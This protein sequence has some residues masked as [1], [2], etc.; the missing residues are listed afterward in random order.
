MQ[1]DEPQDGVSVHAGFPNPAADK[2]LQTLDFNQLLIQHGAST[3]MFR[4]EGNQWESIG[5]FDNDIAVVDRALDPRK[6][7][8]TV[9]WNEQR[10]EFS[11]SHHASMPR[12][13]SCWGVVTNTIHQFRP[14]VAA[15]EG[16]R[17]GK[18]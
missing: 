18:L 10:G 6:N 15:A 13:A 2:S 11:F 9:W 3:Y 14:P 1:E 12:G 8:V 16:R 7:D 4:V 17:R 5:V